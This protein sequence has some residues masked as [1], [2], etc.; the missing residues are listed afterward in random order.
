MDGNDRGRRGRR[1]PTFDMPAAD[2]LDIR[3]SPQD[4]AG[5]GS[6]MARKAARSRGAAAK[7]PAAKKSPPRRGAAAPGRGGGRNAPR[8]GSGGGRGG[9][10]RRRRS[11]LGHLVY[12]TFVLGIWALIAV[13]GVVAYHATQLPPIDQLEVPKRP[14]NIAVLA[15]DGTLLANRG[16]TGGSNVPYEELPDYLPDAFVAIEDRRFWSHWGVDPQGIA[17]ALVTN[18]RGDSGLHGGSTLTQQLAKNLFL[19]QERTISR[20]IQEAILALW[21]ER[22][23]SK[24]EILEL[25]MNRVYFGAGAYG[26]DAAARRYFDKSARDVT[27]SEAAMLAGLVQ[28]PSRLAPTRNPSGAKARAEVVLRA[29]REEGLIDETRLVTALSRPAE[30]VRQEGSGTANYA[31]DYIMDVLDDFVGTVEEDIVVMTTIA[32]DVQAAAEQA[33]TA[34]LAEEGGTYGVSQGAVVTMRPDGAI[35]ALVGGKD[36]R[37]SQFNRATQARRQPGSAFKPFVYLAALEAGLTPDTIREDRPVTIGNWSPENYSRDF[38]GPVTLREALAL[39]LNTIAAQLAAEVGPREVVR[40]AQRLGIASPLEP[41]ATIALGTSE[42]TPLELTGAF[43]AFANGGEGV[44]PYVI[45]E[46]H[47]A[48]GPVLYRRGDLSLGRVVEPEHVAMMNAMMHETF[49]MGTARRAEL[50]GWAGAGKTGTSQEFRDAWFVG[51]TGALVTG[52]WV[53]NDDGTPTR[54][55][56]GGNLPLTIWSRTMNAALAGETPVAL[57]GGGV[58]QGPTQ[59]WNAP[60]AQGPVAPPANEN[61]DWQ[62]PTEPGFIERIFGIY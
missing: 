22:T 40:V 11:L 37:A 19:T 6:E 3:L 15:A 28:Q 7:A 35:V 56:S 54:R 49:T 60:V 8:G 46:I 50:P 34:T 27:L 29:M 10:P 53:G 30:A 5:G 17:R 57:P 12:S 1:E 42:V 18:L 31:A 21:L 62:R 4:R 51:Y 16:E 38:R 55:A 61:S 44:I 20:K 45:S 26:V 52:V 59:L 32:P 25:Y 47:A 36:Y 58:W 13:A 2:A 14:P 24:A 23:Y 33:L 48:D 9:R 41:N 43:A 39:S